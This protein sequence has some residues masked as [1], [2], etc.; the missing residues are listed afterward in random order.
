[1]NPTRIKFLVAFFALLLASDLHVPFTVCAKFLALPAARSTAFYV[2][3][4]GNDGWS[5]RLA[6]PN[7][8]RTDGPFATIGRAR[9]SV[10]LLKARRQL[11]QPVIIYVRGGRYFLSEPIVFT[12]EDSGTFE[13]P[14][15]Y[16]A[17]RGE[18][19]VFSGGRLI[20]HW[21]ASGR[22][23][24]AALLPDV[25]E[26]RW[27]FRQLFVNSERRYRARIPDRGFLQ[28]AALPGVD[29]NGKYNTPANNFRF[30]PGDLSARWTNLTDV[31]V[32]MLHF[33]VDTHLPI[34]RINEATRMVNFARSSRRRFT[35]GFRG[36][37]ARYYVDNVYEGLDWPGEWYLNRK[38]GALSYL[39]RR[40]EDMRRAD[41]IAPR[42]STLVR[43]DGRPEENTFVEYINLRGLTF[44]HNEWELPPNDAGDVTAAY[45]VPAAVVARGLRHSRI[46]DS[47]FKNLGTY[48]IELGDG[49]TDNRIN[50]NEIAHM[51]AGGIKISGGDANSSDAIRTGRNQITNNHLHHLGEIFHSGVGI[52]LR[53]AAD[54]RIAHNLI[55]HT[56][57]TAIS[58]GWV[59]GYGPSVSVKNIIE[60]NHIHTVG[61]R[62]LNDMGGI[63]LLG[64]A[65]GT[66]VRNNLI[67]DVS[68][69][70][71]G[72]WGIYA[73]E[74]SS[75]VLVENNLVYRTTHGGFNQHYGRDNTIRN[76]IFAFGQEA[77]ITRI[78]A[79]THLSFT[80]ERNIIYWDEG[81]LLGRNWEGNGYRFNRNLYF[82][83][84]GGPMQFANW[85][86]AEWQRRGQ[87]TEGLIVDPLFVNPA[88]SNFT[89]EPRSPAFKLGFQ[90]IDISKIGMEQPYR[91]RLH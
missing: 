3:P 90:P 47:T 34:A 40:G 11:T 5:G 42:L 73:D 68:A 85:S 2:S 23:L 88:R 57:Y 76:N 6:R 56:N 82:K 30:K 77:Q 52:L 72:G 20:T 7:R 1:M 10:R 91:K 59:W 13:A 66:V 54:N 24:Y 64:P 21:K 74:G 28:V 81:L 32:V 4:S 35:E 17:Y 65:P 53:H 62:L 18:T 80:F 61:Q 29:P 31:E 51:G 45:E 39:P 14:I 26:G 70:Q 84:G 60:Y 9:D 36:G 25:P 27:N 43:F 33:W 22:G 48:A 37:N 44:S 19:P 8:L 38:T 49:S 16:A 69:H 46:E 55:H 71:F 58:I 79:E 67:R 86:F 63:Y 15:T 83:K 78:R 89:L 12:P 87:D 50:G 41:V 75:G